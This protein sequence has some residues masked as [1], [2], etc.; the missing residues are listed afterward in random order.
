MKRKLMESEAMT[1]ASPVKQPSCL[2]GDPQNFPALSDVAFFK[3]PLVGYVINFIAPL[4]TS[5]FMP[6]KIKVMNLSPVDLQQ[7]HRSWV[8]PSGAV[9]RTAVAQCLAGSRVLQG[10]GKAGAKR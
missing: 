4:F 8:S 1:F 5:C 7:Q 2:N 6:V 3:L 9:G 10:N